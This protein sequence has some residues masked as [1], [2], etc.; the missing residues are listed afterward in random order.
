MSALRK[1]QVKVWTKAELRKENLD[2]S[3]IERMSPPEVMAVWY[4]ELDREL[5]T[6]TEPFDRNRKPAASMFES[7]NHEIPIPL[8]LK[9]RKLG[10]LR[11]WIKPSTDSLRVHGLPH[12]R[13]HAFEINWELPWPKVV[14]A[15]KAWGESQSFY[16]TKH[17]VSDETDED[18]EP[19]NRP[20]PWPATKRGRKDF[21]DG[22]L[23]ELM[24]YRISSA[25][26][27]YA[28]GV[29]LLNVLERGP[30]R[31]RRHLQHEGSS[32]RNLQIDDTNWC[33]AGRRSRERIRIYK[34]VIDS[35]PASPFVSLQNTWERLG[36]AYG[37][38][39]PPKSFNAQR[40][41]VSPDSEL[42]WCLL[43][44]FS[45]ESIDGHRGDEWEHEIS[46]RALLGF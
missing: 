33:H 45:K 24:I 39:A 27:G 14:N 32:T 17:W 26:L 38:S 6:V 31:V 23:R 28:E 19:D 44:S 11:S 43:R 29:R 2:F 42:A 5:G 34:S 22:W 9:Y 3:F 13:I 7:P 15:F 36:S 46:R 25:G 41:R 35:L 40:E 20:P 4:W 1:K 12:S 8:G 37:R 30:R 16:K 21:C 10:S 18:D